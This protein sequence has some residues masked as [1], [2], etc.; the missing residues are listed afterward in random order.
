MPH[1][2]Q[3]LTVRAPGQRLQLDRQARLHDF[4]TVIPRRFER[5][6]QIREDPLA[7]VTDL[8]GLA[9][10]QVRSP[11]DPRTEGGT[12]DLM[13]ETDTEHRHFRTA[14]DQLEADSRL[15]RPSGTG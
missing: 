4:Q 15:L 1:S 13:T 6:R 7:E 9:M 3:C 2:H 12:Q 5:I 10:H 8:R 11:L 14:L